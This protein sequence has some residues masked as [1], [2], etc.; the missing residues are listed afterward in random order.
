MLSMAKGNHA[1][2]KDKKTMK[3]KQEVKKTVAKKK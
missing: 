3:P 2:K 1:Q